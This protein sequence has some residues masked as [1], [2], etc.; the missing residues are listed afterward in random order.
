MTGRKPA[1]RPLAAAIALFV[2]GAALVGCSASNPAPSTQ[3]AP[4]KVAAPGI[5]DWTVG[6][7]PLPLRPDGYGEIEPTPA[8]LVNRRLPTKDVLPPPADNTFHSTIAAVPADVLARSTW[9]PACP[10]RSDQLRYLTMSFWG[11]DG[12]PHTGEMLVNA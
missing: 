12:K 6:A 8:T 5:S 10:V 11:F 9:Q 3:H 2:V 1:R 7:T 4:L